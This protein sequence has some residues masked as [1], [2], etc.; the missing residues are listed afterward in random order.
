M[1]SQKEKRGVISAERRREHLLYIGDLQK[2]Q[3]KYRHISQDIQDDIDNH[4]WLANRTR[5]QNRADV[6]QLLKN[7]HDAPLTVQEIVEDTGL[8]VWYVR[9]VLDE[10]QAE[11]LV[12]SCERD[13]QEGERG[14]LPLGYSLTPA[15]LNR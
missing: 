1:T 6:L 13:R 10:L 3:T 14:N 15:G 2:L 12:T 4:V 8:T 5:E 9:A 7:W 11:G